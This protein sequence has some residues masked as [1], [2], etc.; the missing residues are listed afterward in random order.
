MPATTAVYPEL[1]EEPALSLPKDSHT[2]GACSTIGPAGLNLRRLEGVSARLLRAGA[3][4]RNPER[5]L[6]RSSGQ[7]LP[8]NYNHR[9]G[10]G[11]IA[12]R[13]ISIPLLLLLSISSFAADPE[14]YLKSASSP[15]YPPLAR[16][17]RIEGSVTLRFTV[18]E[19][20]DTTDVEATSGH[21]ILQEAAI[22]NI[23]GWKFRPPRCACRVKR[24]AVLIYALSR[25]QASAEIP[26]VTVKWF[27][28]APVIRAEIEAGPDL[29]Q[30]QP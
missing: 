21:K 12:M 25:E 22:A 2:L 9:D 3:F 16:Q 24:E 6:R 28:K 8:L 13:R 7:I 11:G 4:C 27:L 10:Q 1:A 26:T 15:F 29:T 23:Q 30:W 14:P 19:L 20:G 18:N 17:A 5:F